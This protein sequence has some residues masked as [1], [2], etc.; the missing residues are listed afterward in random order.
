[1]RFVAGIKM[2]TETTTFVDVSVFW[3]LNNR[4]YLKAYQVLLS[5]FNLLCLQYCKQYLSQN[6]WSYRLR[7]AII[8]I[9]FYPAAAIK[10]AFTFFI[11]AKPLDTFTKCY[12]SEDL[13]YLVFLSRLSKYVVLD[14]SKLATITLLSKKKIKYFH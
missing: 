4:N 1:M 7:K 9:P 13:L 2:K 8:S 11:T 5:Y 10:I 12:F 14:D 6:H 3:L